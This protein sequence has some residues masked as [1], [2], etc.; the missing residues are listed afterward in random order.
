MVQRHSQPLEK[1]P[2]PDRRFQQA[3]LDIVGPI[4]PSNSFTHILTAVI[5]FAGSALPCPI[6][7]TSAGTVVLVF[8]DRQILNQ[9]VPS[10]TTT[11]RGLQFQSAV[12]Q[13]STRI[14]GVNHVNTTAYIQQQ[15][16]RLRDFDAN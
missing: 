10:T 16:A 4:P 5:R 15:M 1:F 6:T 12:S 9:R 8:L 13:E 2:L 11:D 7:D 14:L 3:H